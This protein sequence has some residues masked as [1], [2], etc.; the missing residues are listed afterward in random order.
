MAK[1][2]KVI[3]YTIIPKNDDEDYDK[4][5]KLSLKEFAKALESK[6]LIAPLILYNS[7]LDIPMDMEE[8]LEEYCIYTNKNFVI[9]EV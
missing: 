8:E 6:S 9:E 3:K 4:N 7:D 1:T 5:F 2:D